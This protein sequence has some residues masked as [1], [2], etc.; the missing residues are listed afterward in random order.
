MFSRNSD[1]T[2]HREIHTE[3]C[4]LCNAVFYKRLPL[5]FKTSAHSF[6]CMHCAHECKTH[7]ALEKHEAKHATIKI[8][9]CSVCKLGFKMKSQ[10]S[11]H[12][13]ISHPYL[14]GT[15]LRAE[16]KSYKC[17][18]CNRV[19]AKMKDRKLHMEKLHSNLGKKNIFVSSL[20]EE[21]QC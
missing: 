11:E 18:V 10:L 3:R 1:L 15:E 14:K 16:E 7:S 4:V 17:S 13:K 8:N 5:H 20:W 19:F 9:Q 6:K 2:R 12:V 21:I